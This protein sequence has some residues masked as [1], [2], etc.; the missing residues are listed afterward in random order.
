MANNYIYHW[1]EGVKNASRQSLHVHFLW[2]ALWSR[3]YGPPR[4]P[5]GQ[6][7]IILSLSCK[8]NFLQHSLFCA[9]NV[10]YLPRGKAGKFVGLRVGIS[11]LFH[12]EAVLQENLTP[13]KIRL[14]KLWLPC[15]W[16]ESLVSHRELWFPYYIFSFSL[17]ILV[18]SEMLMSW[19]VPIFAFKLL[20]GLVDVCWSPMKI[21][22]TRL[23]CFNQVE[24]F[25]GTQI[26]Q[27]IC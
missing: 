27:T 1:G 17:N 4:E 22:K 11:L 6:C 9:L 15:L 10:C 2:T 25:G 21:G 5:F 13:E 19:P 7:F 23:W 24:L 20:G 18:F 3:L 12:L 16:A 26:L 14:L 8:A